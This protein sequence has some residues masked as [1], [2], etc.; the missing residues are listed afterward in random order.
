[1]LLNLKNRILK[2][3]PCL[4]RATNI[5]ASTFE[6][7]IGMKGT[8]VMH[9]IYIYTVGNEVAM[10]MSTRTVPVVHLVKPSLGKAK[11][12]FRCAA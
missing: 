2:D 4:K 3:S 1:M 10:L 6:A 11:G 9:C 7:N 12:S 8:T 5:A